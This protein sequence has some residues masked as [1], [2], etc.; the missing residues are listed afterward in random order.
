LTEIYIA[1][2]N[3]VVSVTIVI[4]KL[5]QK[6]A[7]VSVEVSGKV[8]QYIKITKS[9]LEDENIQQGRMKFKV[10]KSWISSNNID[11]NTISLFRYSNNVWNKLST[12]KVS[13]DSNYVY[14]DAATPGFSYFAVSGELKAG[15]TTTVPSV[16]TSTTAPELIPLPEELKK[17][18]WLVYL[19]IFLVVVLVVFLVWK[20][21]QKK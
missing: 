14:F 20:F 9:N 6:P 19:A 7:D 12:L 15:A 18:G 13:E 2:K 8:Y 4:E 3:R 10:L 17:M 11:S 21:W 16:T 5:S 1:V